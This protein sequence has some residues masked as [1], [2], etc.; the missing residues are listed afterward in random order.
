MNTSPTEK[1]PASIQKTPEPSGQK[2]KTVPPQTV[3]GF[4]A[5]FVT[6]TL[7]NKSKHGNYS[8]E[9]QK[10]VAKLIY[11]AWGSRYDWERKITERIVDGTDELA[12]RLKSGVVLSNANRLSYC[13]SHV[14]YGR[15]RSSVEVQTEAQR[16]LEKA[17]AIPVPFSIFKAAKLS[18]ENARII[19]KAPSETITVELETWQDGKPIKTDET[20]HYVGG[21]LLAIR[22][23]YFLFDIDRE[24]IKHKIFNPFVVRLPRPA[25]SI[26]DAY[27]QLK[28]AKVVVAGM[29]NRPVERQGEWFF[30]KRYE[31]LP[32]LPNPPEELVKLANNPPDA[33]TMGAVDIMSY[34]QPGNVYGCTFKKP[35]Q[36]RAYNK[37]ADQWKVAEAKLREYTPQTGSLRQGNSRPNTVEKFVNYNGMVLV[38][39]TIKHSGREH[40]DV[41]LHGWWEA[42][43][44]T[45]VK[46]WQVTG[47]ID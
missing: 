23:N 8:I 17:G 9:R 29:E 1:A 22:D 44:N 13:G 35:R 6:N 31:E 15:S 41:E 42:V 16:I 12:V 10:K 19:E 11:T 45:A 4:L 18:V 40:R 43:P 33:R 26:E 37:L 27:L 25:A 5:G 46:S 34:Y 30:I 21:C 28:P 36:E 47:E 24:E 14:V 20:R 39:G 38:S 2:S 32:K 3:E 7:G